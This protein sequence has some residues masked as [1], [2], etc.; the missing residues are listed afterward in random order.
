MTSVTV[1][2]AASWRLAR[3]EFY[4]PYNGAHSVQGYGEVLLE[5]PAAPSPGAATLLAPQA[6]G[7]GKVY[8][9]MPAAKVQRQLE[10]VMDDTV[11]VEGTTVAFSTVIEAMKLFFDKWRIEDI[12][13]PPLTP[14]EP[15]TMS[16]PQAADLTPMP[17]GLPIPEDELLPPKG[18]G[19]LMWRNRN[20]H[21][22]D[23][24]S[25]HR[26]ALLRQS[27]TSPRA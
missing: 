10:T 13:N 24:Q 19:V 6:T 8:G 7:E 25:G 11:E 22:S 18:I 5:E 4:T 23:R 27:R 9:A 12:E 26:K 17:I 20:L 21:R 1:S 16:I 3:V 15:T 2:V 14:P